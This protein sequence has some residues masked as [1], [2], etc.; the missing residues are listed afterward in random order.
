MHFT[1]FITVILK[2]LLWSKIEHSIPLL[3]W[4]EEEKTQRTQQKLLVA[5]LPHG[6]STAVNSMQNNC[7][8][9]NQVHFCHGQYSF[10]K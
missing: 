6:L 2:N 1:F 4:K 9:L 3:P 10:I 8:D 5:I 7:Q